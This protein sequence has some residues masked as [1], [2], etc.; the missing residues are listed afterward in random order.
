MIGFAGN[1]FS[2]LKVYPYI[3]PVKEESILMSNSLWGVIPSIKNI[4]PPS[5]DY[6]RSYYN[7]P[8][9]F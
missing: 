6:L 7:G 5:S 2:P 3:W 9:I 4:E 1:H 8:S